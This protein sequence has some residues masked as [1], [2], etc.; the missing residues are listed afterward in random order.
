MLPA[1]EGGPRIGEDTLQ[2]LAAVYAPR[3]SYRVVERD[4][5]HAAPA[6]PCIEIPYGGVGCVELHEGRLDAYGAH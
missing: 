1:F 4:R 2:A 3:Q 6:E 5:F